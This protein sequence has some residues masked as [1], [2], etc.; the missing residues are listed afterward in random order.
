MEHNN[1]GER[2]DPFRSFL[3]ALSQMP[4]LTCVTGIGAFGLV[5]ATF[6]RGFPVMKS[7]KSKSGKVIER[8]DRLHHFET[9]R[10]EFGFSLR[11]G[12]SHR[13]SQ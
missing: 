1:A 9:I 6:L 13:N 4:P 5:F 8:R 10:D 11:I 3:V 7:G 12:M 2:G